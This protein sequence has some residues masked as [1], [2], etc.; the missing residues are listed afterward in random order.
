MNVERYESMK[1]EDYTFGKIQINGNVYSK[2]LWVI[3]GKIDKR[4]KSIAKSKFGTSHKICAK[5]LKKIVTKKTK[6]VIIG[7]GAS[8]LVTLTEKASKF[9]DDE[10][11]KL[12]IHKTSDLI[13]KKIEISD[14]DSAIIHLTC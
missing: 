13:S 11:I 7:S 3:N 10:D 1:I 6:R 8:G 5:E 12:E 2:D 9:L 14:D 4:D